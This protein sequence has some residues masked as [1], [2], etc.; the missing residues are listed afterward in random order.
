MN[1]GLT[2]A[3]EG[4]VKFT[5]D[6]MTK[7]QAELKLATDKIQ[8]GTFTMN[9]AFE[10]MMRGANLLLNGIAGSAV[11]SMDFATT[12]TKYL[13]ERPLS[14]KPLYVGQPGAWTLAITTPLTNAQNEVLPN[15]TVD[16]VA[17][18]DGA[19]DP[20]VVRTVVQKVSGGTY[21]G[22]VT[23]KSADGATTKPLVVKIQVA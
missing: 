21:A 5:N 14:T 22:V 16:P 12:L 17:L 7:A 8:A 19:K 4:L 20:F 15:V 10:G 11:E 23:A 9:D 6:Y 1:E 18:G 3:I 2:E 13:G